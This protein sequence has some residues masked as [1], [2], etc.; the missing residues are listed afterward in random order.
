MGDDKLPLIVEELAQIE[1]D[2]AIPKNVRTHI[3]NAIYALQ[4]KE[5]QVEVKIDRALAEL[6]DADED[7][8]ISQYTRTKIWGVVSALESKNK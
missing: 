6:G 2:S 4:K 7:P 1:A 3:K 5:E 8:N